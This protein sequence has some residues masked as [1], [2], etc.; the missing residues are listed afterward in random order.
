MTKKKRRRPSR[1]RTSMKPMVSQIARG[2]VWIARFVYLLLEIWDKLRDVLWST[3]SV[4]GDL[5]D[6]KCIK[7]A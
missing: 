1:Q 2:V 4:H 5:G 6:I 7:H 3:Y